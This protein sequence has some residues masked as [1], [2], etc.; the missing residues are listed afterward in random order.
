MRMI[1]GDS[2][3]DFAGEDAV[4][5]AEE[6]LALDANPHPTRARTQNNERIAAV[7]KHYPF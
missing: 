3:A 6:G 1:F 5:A 7:L 4:F 2:E